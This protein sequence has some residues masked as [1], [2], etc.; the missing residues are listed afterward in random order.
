M[1]EK[2][3]TIIR[4]AI[5]HARDTM[6]VVNG[7]TR[8]RDCVLEDIFFDLNRMSCRITE[9]VSPSRAI[10]GQDDKAPWI[11]Q[12]RFNFP[13]KTSAADKEEIHNDYR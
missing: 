4:N 12:K 7:G 9:M 8:F 1:D 3:L 6:E 13:Q 5:R 2:D 11:L 10:T